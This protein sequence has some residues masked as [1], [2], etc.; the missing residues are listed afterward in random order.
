MYKFH[1]EVQEEKPKHIELTADN[2]ELKTL[3]FAIQN[4]EPVILGIDENFKLDFKLD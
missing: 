1:F 2:M 3:K 4:R